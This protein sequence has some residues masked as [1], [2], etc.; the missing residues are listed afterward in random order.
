[1]KPDAN[2]F[3]IAEP[4]LKETHFKRAV[5]LLCS[6]DAEGS[7]GLTLNHPFEHTLDELIDG[8]KEKNIPVFLGG[9]VAMDTIHILHQLPDQ[10]KESHRIGENLYW[11]GN[12][13]DLLN[14]VK[15]SKIDLKK[16]RFYLGYSGWS[17]GQLEEELKENTWLVTGADHRIVFDVHYEHCW[18]ES[19]RRVG[20]P[21]DEWIH[22]PNDPHLN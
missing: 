2:K 19:L 4:F 6:H 10:I 1:M 5:I 13:M 16:I 15:A 17:A 14:G 8:V 20:S 12:W 9:P 7:I 21:Y 3:L 22:F 11:G 18:K